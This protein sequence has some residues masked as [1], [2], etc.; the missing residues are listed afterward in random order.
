MVGFE[1]EVDGQW[2]FWENDFTTNLQ[3]FAASDSKE[4]VCLAD[5]ESEIFDHTSEVAEEECGPLSKGRWMSQV[6]KF[7]YQ[8][9]NFDLAMFDQDGNAPANN[10][11]VF[12]FEM[13]FVPDI[14]TL[15]STDGN[16]RIHKQLIQNSQSITPGERLFTVNARAVLED[17]SLSQFE[18]IG[19]IIQGDAPWTESLWGDERLFF[20]HTLI[21]SDI[22]QHKKNLDKKGRKAFKKVT[23]EL[24][25]FNFEKY[26]K[27]PLFIPE[28]ADE[29][30]VIEG[31]VTSSCPFAFI[32]D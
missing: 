21:S 14:S 6:N 29:E 7:I 11:P 16:S 19:E 12:P 30:D 1:T 4:N 27:W 5:D 26:G 15:G 8:N 32:I 18:K 23:D 10:N 25:T 31:M 22:Q 13:Q 3:S 28:E 24:P 9:A 2:N 20:S 17:G